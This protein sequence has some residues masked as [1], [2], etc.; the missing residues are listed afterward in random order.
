L[1]GNSSS[2]LAPRLELYRAS[3]WPKRLE[4]PVAQKILALS[5]HSD[6]ESIG[7]GGFLLAHAGK[8]EI[9][10]VNVY[11]GDGGG[12]L[13]D[14]P[15]RND[16]AY[17]SRLIDVRAR[18]LDQ[19]AGR[20]QA[21]QVTR[22]GVSDCDGVPGATEVAAL[23]RML[24]TFTPEVVV[25]PWMLD[26][27]PHHKNTNRLLADAAQG[28]G[29]LALGYEVWSLLSPNAYL[30]ISDVLDCKRDLI[31]LHVSQLRTVDYLVYSDALA[32]VRA[33]HN[34]VRE[35]RTGAVEAFLALPSRDYCDLVR[36]VIKDPL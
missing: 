14:G 21:S 32:R 24:Q 10:I 23:R 19:V 33:F 17:R 7:C 25:L 6:D 1:V 2:E 27:H 30:D 16:A 3:W 28:L 11:N 22:F 20:L 5:A 8:A 31:A 34:P 4:P 35:N 26:N 36:R 13:E 15:W 9:R 18:E 12:A 29:F